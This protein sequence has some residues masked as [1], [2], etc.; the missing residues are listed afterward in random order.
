V[1]KKTRFFFIF[2]TIIFCLSI[3]TPGLAAEPTSWMGED[4]NLTPENTVIL[5]NATDGRFSQDFSGLLKHLR[6]DWVVLESGLIPEASQENN[7]ILI[8]H[9]DAPFSGEVMRE[10]LT[11]DEIEILRNAADQHHL[12]TIESPWLENGTIYICSGES[13]I[14]RR[15]AAE[16]AVRLIMDASPPSA[17]W[18]LNPYGADPDDNL[19]EM[20]SQLQYDWE[21]TELP[22]ED[23]LSV[24]NAGSPRKVTQQE[25]IEDVEQLFSLLS[26]GYGGF[27]FFNQNGIFDQTKLEIEE[28]LS[29]YSSLSAKEFSDL[30]YE[31]LN[32]LVDCHLKIGD[33]Q[34]A[35]HQNFWYDTKYEFL[36]D[37]DGFL[38]KSRRK[39]YLVD[40]INGED[41]AAYLL[42]SLNQQGDPIYRL[43][44][45]SSEQPASIQLTA[46][47]EN[48]EHTFEINLQHSDFAYYS[49]QIFSEDVLGGI[50]VVRIRSFGDSAPNQ[51]NQFAQTGTSCRKEPVVILDLRGNGGGNERW[52]IQWIQRLTGQYAGPVFATSELESKTSLAGRANAFAYWNSQDP[53]NPFYVSNL[54]SY[55]AQ[56]Q[57]V[58]RGEK[59]PDWTFLRYPQLPL[60]PNDTTIVVTTNEYVA[61]AGEGMVMRVSQAENVMVVGENTMGCLSFGNISLHHLPN[62]RIEVWMP[63]NFGLFL[64][65]E[66]REE[67]GL[68]PDLWVP[69]EDA[70]DFAAAAIR[71]G[72]I[73][74]SKPLP[75][76]I[77]NEK[78]ISESSLLNM[79]P[80]EMTSWLVIALYG[81]LAI[82]MVFFLR[83]KL[84]ILFVIDALWIGMSIYWFTNRPEKTLGFAF[85]F[86][87]IILLVSGLITL[88]LQ[89]K[90]S[91]VETE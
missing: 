18:I 16:E 2:G 90:R 75:E 6:V 58:E 67:V 10:L 86:G 77:Q 24:E 76:N 25:A 54:D 31:E 12:M 3:T 74:T 22:L 89:K 78:L 38:F 27:G 63:I 32:F 68:T 69:A 28:K 51:L 57:A 1:R 43:G 48:G 80:T 42:P 39:T 52:P 8:G 35:D 21:D 55:T 14:Q 33:H 36:L 34:F 11:D 91:A 29:S 40:S 62:S 70:V 44:L 53:E 20:V 17:N 60:I 71:S 66:F 47:D 7:L 9:P 65:Q 73:T 85:F 59:E 56:A 61:S 72:T 19:T 87:A 82:G 26:H 30:L 15:N 45:L 13:L 83:K 64:D 23:I 50:P 49:Q 46:S 5:S 37:N 41:P 88:I 79:L 4:S 84:P 81:I